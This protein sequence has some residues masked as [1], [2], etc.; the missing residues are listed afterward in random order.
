MT[1]DTDS[2]EP[3]N[4]CG[5]NHYED[6]GVGDDAGDGDEGPGT[7]CE[8]SVFDSVR[9]CVPSEQLTTHREID[10][11]ADDDKETDAGTVQDSGGESDA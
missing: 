7:Q 4:R 8:L 6:N 11:E 10:D 2:H 9:R 5:N 3:E 1:R